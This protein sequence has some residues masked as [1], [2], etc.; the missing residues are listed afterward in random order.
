MNFFKTFLACL[1]ALLAV[2]F[3]FMLI[4]LGFFGAIIASGSKDKVN[5]KDNSVLM[6][7]L[8]KQIVENYDTEDPF[9]LGEIIPGLGAAGKMGLYQILESIERAKTDDKIKG[10]YLNLGLGVPAGWAS[11]RTIRKALLDFKTSDKFIYAYAEV[12]PEKSY[13][14]ASLADSIFMP[15]TGI[16]EFNGLAY[17]PYFLTGMFE[18]LEIKPKVYRVGTYKSAVEPYILKEMSEANKE[19]ASAFIGDIW[20]VFISDIAESRGIP[21]GEL[22]S[23]ATEFVFGDGRKAKEYKMIDRAAF[24]DEVRERLKSKLSLKEDEKIR[25]VSLKDYIKAAPEAKSSKNRIAV[26]FAE[27]T[28]QSGKSRDGVIGSETI[29]K[30]LRLAR[31]DDKV[32]AVVLRVNSPGG[33]ALA[34]EMMAREVAITAK[35]KPVIASM[36]DVAASGG[37]YISALADKIVAE[38]NTITGSIG[39]F[40]LMYQTEDF[41]TNKLGITFDQV[42]T[43]EHANFLNPNYEPSEFEENLMQ[44]YIEQGYGDFIT[45]VKDGRE[46]ADSAAVDAIAQGR[47]W[48]G[49]R[50]IGINLV[51]SFGNLDDAIAMAAEM[52][53]LE[54]DDYSIRL[55]PKAK[56]PLE[57]MLSGM[58]GVRQQILSA[59][60]PLREEM[61]TLNKLR[62]M[63]PASGVYA[64][65]PFSAE[66]R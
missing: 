56:S 64:L 26:V 16:I 35:E 24:E 11:T 44:R 42:E 33:S 14:L 39:I 61:E 2:G 49:K 27:G 9:D 1:V 30:A 52:A 57:E 4:T 48:S 66:I 46:F 59:A 18:K 12:Y 31:E 43:N 28:I 20:D 3:F 23:L 29:V 6:I 65:M 17:A 45:V 63:V 53:D 21:K 38:E 32:K 19:Q 37:Y 51:D 60:N 58:P 10:I 8:D 40:G 36:G 22:N 5:L 41:F 54:K 7:Q 47:V 15:K 13:Y 62:Q 34:S 25:F 50:A 55:L